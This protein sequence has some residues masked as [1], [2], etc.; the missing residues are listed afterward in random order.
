[1]RN[2]FWRAALRIL[3]IIDIPG[4]LNCQVDHLRTWRICAEIPGYRP[5]IQFVA[6]TV[7]DH[8][9]A[10]A[11]ASFFHKDVCRLGTG[12][13]PVAV[14][15][16]DADVSSDREM[17]RGAVGSIGSVADAPLV[18]CGNSAAAASTRRVGFSRLSFEEGVEG[19]DAM[20]SSL[21]SPN[22]SR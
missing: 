7:A 5:R 21:S 15:H 2:P 1:M 17:G 3:I 22:I 11:A 20:P 10:G 4:S 6:R 12:S 13:G 9:A 16:T 18:R 19:T 8:A 14:A